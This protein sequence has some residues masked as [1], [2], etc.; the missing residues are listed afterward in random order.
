MI[1]Y[2]AKGE[3]GA[4]GPGCSQWIAAEGVVEWDTFK[5]L[6]VFLERLG[7]ATKFPVLLN[8]WGEGDLKVATT[9]GKIIREHGLDVSVGTTRVAGCADA[10]SEAACFALKRGGE[11]LEAK[12]DRSFVVCDDVCALILA[13]GVHRTLPLGAT[14]VIGPTHIQNRL[15]P[16]V[17]AERQQRLLAR[18]SDQYRLYLTQ[19]G[20][21]TDIVDLID[22]NS[23]SG[24][25]TQLTRDAWQRLGLVTGAGP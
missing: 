21:R 3:D 15:A 12:I 13:G 14:L 6:F 7:P 23:Q 22:Q 9:L 5:R 11:S 8:V 24:R 20:V 17:S 25:T 19:M 4:C 16:N 1:F 2:L 18:F 10:A